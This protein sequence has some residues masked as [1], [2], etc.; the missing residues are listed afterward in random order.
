MADSLWR[1]ALRLSPAAEGTTGSYLGGSRGGSPADPNGLTLLAQIEL[2]DLQ[3]ALRFDW[4]PADGALLFFYDVENQPWGSEPQDRGGFD[5]QWI[6][7]PRPCGALKKID[8]AFER[9]QTLP[10]L[11][12]SALAELNLNVAE[13]RMYSDLE[14]E[15][16]SGEQPQH[17]IGGWPQLFEG[18]MDGGLTP[19]PASG[20]AWRLLLQLDSDDALQWQWVDRGRLYF[21]V[22]ESDARR[23]DFSKSW[24]FLGSS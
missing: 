10:S 2:A 13:Y 12:S 23:G 11:G 20:D 15:F 1:P 4:L 14:M 17:R 8:I 16:D 6:A 22:L 21:W 18:D 24:C 7:Q 5:V 9:I 3:R 19:V